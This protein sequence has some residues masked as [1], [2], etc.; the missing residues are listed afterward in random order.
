MPYKIGLVGCGA[1]G[2]EIAKAIDRGDISAELVAVS[3]RSSKCA[4]QLIRSLENK[5]VKADIIELADL[6]DIVVEAASQSA[7]PVVAEAALRKGK[8][9]MIMSVGAM[10]DIELYREIR[11]LATDHGAKVY[12]PSGAISGLDGL[13]SASVGVIRKVTLTTTKNPANL[14][15]APYIEQNKINLGSLQEPTL[16]FE[17]KAADAVKAFP[18][19]VNV[20]ATICLAARKGDVRV[21]IIADPQIKVNRHEILAEGDFGR[22]ST[23]VENVPSPKNPKTSY[24]AA[25][26][27]IATLRSIVEPIKIGT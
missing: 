22:I 15:G 12:I 9:L 5:P 3:D 4:E 25:L 2:T 27:A 1:I 21:R 23:K 10:A 13:K 24:L 17:G 8:S 6:S 20:A 18:A 19:N 26:S 7:V 16:V 11:K 14:E